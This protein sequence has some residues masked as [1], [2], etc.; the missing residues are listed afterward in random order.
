M[1]SNR[2]MAGDF[3][4]CMI[5]VLP[6]IAGTL[7]AMARIFACKYGYFCLQLHV[8]LPAIAGVFVCQF[9]VFFACKS[10]QF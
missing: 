3:I 8:F 10:K 1:Q 9:N 6:A 5:A 4:R 2:K 7:T